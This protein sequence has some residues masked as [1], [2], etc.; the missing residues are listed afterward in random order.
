MICCSFW[1]PYE[2]AVIIYWYTQKLDL[3]NSFMCR[4]QKQNLIETAEVISKIE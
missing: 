4:L 3:P 2:A 1:V